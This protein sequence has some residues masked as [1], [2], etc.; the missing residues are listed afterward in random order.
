[1][2]RDENE[3]LKNV[4]GGRMNKAKPVGKTAFNPQK[5]A[6]PT[7]PPGAREGVK[8][9]MPIVPPHEL[10]KYPQADDK[11]PFAG[12]RSRSF[13]P[14]LNEFA[15]KEIA[16]ERGVSVEQLLQTPGRKLEQ[17]VT[18][19]EPTAP[20]PQARNAADLKRMLDVQKKSA[21]PQRAP[22]SFTHPEPEKFPEPPRAPS[23]ESQRLELELAALDLQKKELELRRQLVEAAQIEQPPLPPAPSNKTRVVH[24]VLQRMRE[25]LSLDNL[26]PATIEIEGLLFE[27]LPPPPGT[28]PWILEKFAEL[29]QIDKR[30]G[31]ITLQKCTAALGLVRVDGAPIAEVLGLVPEGAV[32]NPLRPDVGIRIMTAQALYEMLEGEPSLDQL[33]PFNPVIA[34]KLAQVFD[35]AFK[36]LDLKSSLDP[37]LRHFICPIPD[38]AE[39]GD[40][41]VAKGTPVFCQVHG[42]PMEDRGLSAEVKS[43]PLP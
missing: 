28:Y 13:D 21:A 34:G 14:E 33:F 42:V 8:S 4:M 7:R 16:E 20:S 9:P 27:M 35:Q 43:L 12:D 40:Y 31:Q 3:D 11:T 17:K 24:P 5:P 36:N 23:A 15:L 41:S 37:L 32:T 2:A 39:A 38:C 26:V 22:S 29:N 1:M 18:S 6:A 10:G 30:V 19:M 25:K